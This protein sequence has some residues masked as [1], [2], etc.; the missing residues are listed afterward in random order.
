VKDGG[1]AESDGMKKKKKKKNE[2]AKHTDSEADLVA[3]DGWERKKKKKK[4]NRGDNDNKSTSD[5]AAESSDATI[6]GASES[7]QKRKSSHSSPQKPSK[8]NLTESGAPPNQSQSEDGSNEREKSRAKRKKRKREV[9]VL[10]S[11]DHVPSSQTDQSEGEGA[12]V[13]DCDDLMS[14]TENLGCTKSKSQYSGNNTVEENSSQETEV[15]NAD[16]QQSCGERKKLK[17][18]KKRKNMSTLATAETASGEDGDEQTTATRSAAEPSVRAAKDADLTEN[19]DLGERTTTDTDVIDL[20]SDCSVTTMSQSGKKKRRK[21]HKKKEA[22]LPQAQEITKVTTRNKPPPSEENGGKTSHEDDSTTE[23]D[24]VERNGGSSSQKAERS[25][26]GFLKPAAIPPS[27]V[28]PKPPK[29][30]LSPAAGITSSARVSPGKVKSGTPKESSLLSVFSVTETEV[31]SEESSSEKRVK[32]TSRASHEKKARKL[33][34][35]SSLGSHGKKVHAAKPSA[36]LS[37]SSLLTP[38]PSSRFS[39]ESAVRMF[40]LS[41]SPRGSARRVRPR[42]SPSNIP[43]PKRKHVEDSLGAS[44]DELLKETQGSGKEGGGRGS[45]KVS[46]SDLLADGSLWDT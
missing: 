27:K 24:E 6:S 45:G 28:S 39:S 41:H 14:E 12:L 1:N 40:S 31:S 26:D 18:K 11:Q 23:E 37:R 30:Q 21:K 32:P 17:K 29:V 16:S 15:D 38:S 3:S 13:I 44:L 33:N 2:S 25:K 42:I 4:K 20:S 43:P 10:S 7:P 34:F 46:V 5:N 19:E 35:L 8:E 36:L 9:K 22:A